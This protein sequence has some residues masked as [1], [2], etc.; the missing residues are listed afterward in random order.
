MPDRVITEERNFQWVGYE[1]KTISSTAITLTTGITRDADFALVSIESNPI[2]Y[3]LDGSTVPTSTVG[4][5][6]SAGTV[7]RLE[8]RFEILNFSAIRSGGADATAKISYG[9]WAD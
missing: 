2:N 6:I 3:T 5:N 9:K 8:N 4:H 7:F 1:T